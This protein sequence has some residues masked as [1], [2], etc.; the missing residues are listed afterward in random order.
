MEM[1]KYS[2]SSAEL[3]V[4][5]H[6]PETP[7][8]WRANRAQPRGDHALLLEVRQINSKEK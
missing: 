5:P 3:A 6:L 8:M 1:Q 7:A 4:C 2:T